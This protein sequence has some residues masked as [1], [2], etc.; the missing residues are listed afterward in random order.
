MT[1]IDATGLTRSTYADRLTELQNAYQ[2]IYGASASVDPATPDGQFLGVLAEALSSIDQAIE[3]VYSTMDPNSASGVAISR[4]LRLAGLTKQE[5][6]FSVMSVRLSGTPNT[7]LSTPRVKNSAGN[8]FVYGGASVTLDESG[9]QT[10][11]CQST[12][13]GNFDVGAQTLTIVNPQ[14][15]L[16]SAVSLGGTSGYEA[17][18]DPAQRMRRNK[19]VTKQAVALN[20]A[21]AAAIANIPEIT[22]VAV[23]D[24]PLDTVDS[25]GMPPHSLVVYAF[26][27]VDAQGDLIAEAIW[28]KL[29]PGPTL[30][31]DAPFNDVFYRNITDSKGN[32]HQ[33]P[34]YVPVT[35]DVI[36]QINGL[37]RKGWP[38]DGPARIAQALATWG[39]E[40]LTIGASLTPA[41]LVPVILDAVPGTGLSSIE[42]SSLYIGVGGGAL[43]DATIMI[44]PFQK[45]ILSQSD[46][47]VNVP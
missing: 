45:L 46:V 18:S 7:L 11:S 3:E 12:T 14:Y 30:W 19:S 39:A 31:A 47:E 33:I 16:A 42:I 8:E 20:E 34:I 25:R 4:L 35:L 9:F 29:A 22:D 40:N 23:Y 2:S 41:D 17:E 37:K 44:T 26:G 28:S 38:S 13:R 36:V 15:G 32:L 43:N 24:N 21:M 6:A 27:G 5:G 1:T 10:I